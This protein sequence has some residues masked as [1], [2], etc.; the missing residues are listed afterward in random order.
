MIPRLGVQCIVTERNISIK[1]LCR[2]APEPAHNTRWKN[3]NNV[4]IK[5]HRTAKAGDSLF[6]KEGQCIQTDASGQDAIQFTALKHFSV[7]W[8]HW[9]ILIVSWSTNWNKHYQSYVNKVKKKR[10]KS[11]ELRNMKFC[12]S[13]T[14]SWDYQRYIL[15]WMQE[16]NFLTVPG[17]LIGYLIL[18]FFYQQFNQPYIMD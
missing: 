15:S 2:A 14:F 8:S 4:K 12:N 10:E 11:E 5:K 9:Y 3:C 18:I 1:T 16:D 17:I 7:P 13:W 6:I